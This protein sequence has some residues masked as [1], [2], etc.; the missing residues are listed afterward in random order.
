M[1]DISFDEREEM[2]RQS[3]MLYWWPKILH[4]D[5]PQP[6]TTCIRVRNSDMKAAVNGGPLPDLTPVKDAAGV[7][8]Y[9]LFLRSDHMSAKHEWNRTC[10][11]AVPEY[12]VQQIFNVA[13]TTYLSSMMD[14][15]TFNAVFLRQ[16][17]DLE[18]AGFEA[19]G[20]GFPVA[21]EVRC[22]IRDGK[23][24]CQHP[25]WFADAIHEWA[26]GIDAFAGKSKS[27]TK[28]KEAIP[29][30][31]EQMLDDM[32]VL[33]DADQSKIDGYL[34]LVGEAFEGY[35]SV[36]FAKGTDGRWYL[37]DMAR[38]KVSF[39]LAGCKHG[40]PLPP[41]PPPIAVLDLGGFEFEE[42]KT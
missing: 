30:N 31:W 10:Y 42:D 15:I 14:E 7:M 17:L 40:P 23:K 18:R 38:G 20:H 29:Q 4:L 32:N 39:H 27:D 9:P 35:W 24:E 22:F 36:D 21:K 2:E 16:F 26:D 8:G 28:P 12:L 3:S 1:K 34:G 6:R 19:F 33:S 37:L 41:S 5:V 11:V 13:E 25:Y